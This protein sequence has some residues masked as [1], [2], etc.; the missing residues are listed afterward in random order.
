MLATEN[1]TLKKQVASLKKFKETVQK[2]ESGD[3]V[4]N[5][6][7]LLTDEQEANKKLNT[8][9]RTLTK[10]ND[11]LTAKN[12]TLD[13]DKKRLE[14]ELAKLKAEKNPP[15]PKTT[16]TPGAKPTTKPATKPKTTQP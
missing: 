2:N 10:N 12:K 14:T 6:T 16:V 15:K 3:I 4:I 13:A 1:D 9:N 5:L 7:N 8:Q 11:E